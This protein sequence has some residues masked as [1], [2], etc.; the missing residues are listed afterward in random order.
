MQ[1]LTAAPRTGF[2]TAEIT[3]LLMA[4]D[5]Q[6]DFGAEL[7]DASLHLVE[8]I[9]ADVSAGSVKRDNLAAVHGTVDLTISRALAWGQARVRPYT[10]LSSATTKLSG[11]R[12]NQGVFILTTPDSALGESPQ[13]YTV[14]G[15]DQLYLL[16]NPVGDST[17]FPAGTNV[18]TAVRAT[19]VAAGVTA[20][21]LLDTTSSTKVLGVIMTW[22]QTSSDSPTFIKIINDL[23]ACIGYRGLW[24]DQDGAFRATPYVDPVARQSEWVLDVGDLVTGIVGDS[25][26]VAADVWSAPNWWR[27]F[28]NNGFTAPVEGAGRYTTQNASTGPSSQASVGIRRAPVE[29]L[30]AVDQASLVVQG[31][32]IKAAAMRVSEVITLK[33]SPMPLW[34]ADRLTLAD[35]A[36]GEPR[37]TQVRTWSMPLDGADMDVVMETV[38]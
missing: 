6:T 8:D 18:L 29:Y 10:L 19:L 24:C 31:D 37:E 7:L 23:L 3:A 30:D 5:L 15:Y 14:T 20:P 13:S 25:R 38:Q 4:P 26:S 11:V 2:T 1:P 28:A 36:L 34:H 12:F 32:A 17:S 21:I 22:P 33:L 9:S 35:E 27:F 16:Q